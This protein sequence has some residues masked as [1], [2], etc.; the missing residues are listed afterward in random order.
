MPEYPIY[1]YLQALKFGQ[2]VERLLWQR[3][4]PVTI[5]VEILEGRQFVESVSM[6]LADLVFVQEN[7]MQMHFTGKHFGGDVL[8]VVVPQ[9]AGKQP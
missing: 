6:D 3:P 5:Q 8:N 2:V 9:V 7:R 1:L 4:D